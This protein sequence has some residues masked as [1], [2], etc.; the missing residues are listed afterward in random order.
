VQQDQQLEQQQSQ[1]DEHQ[2]NQQQQQQQQLQLKL[3]QKPAQ[4]LPQSESVQ[5][6]LQQQQATDQQ[7]EE[8]P[9][10]KHQAQLS[11]D[12]WEQLMDHQTVAFSASSPEP[13]AG[14]EASGGQTEDTPR[15]EDSALSPSTVEQEEEQL[16]DLEQ[17][18][19]E[20]EEEDNCAAAKRCAPLF[21]R[22]TLLPGMI[23]LSG[24]MNLGNAAQIAKSIPAELAGGPAAF[25]PLPLS[26]NSS[27]YL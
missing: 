4:Q 14:V 24:L 1:V 17:A 27:R 26:R 25:P 5:S 12:S 19:N 16:E 22:T 10:A 23:P 3:Q 20:E 11:S 2:Q 15:S 18:A 7:L 13:L 21:S 9:A 6:H 8:Q